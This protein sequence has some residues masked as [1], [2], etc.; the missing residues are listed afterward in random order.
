MLRTYKAWQ[1]EQRLQLGDKWKDEDLIFAAWD[2]NLLRPDTVSS[3]FSG[4]MKSTD[5]PYISLHGLRHTSISLLMYSNKIDPTAIAARSGHART[6][7]TLDTYSH[8]LRAAED[9]AAK[10]LDDLPNPKANHSS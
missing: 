9:M 10:V 7:T 5:L 3:Q 8:V 1:S 2:G 6:S 4:F